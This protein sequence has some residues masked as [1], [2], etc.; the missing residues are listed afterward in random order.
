MAWLKLAN[1]LFEFVEHS[2]DTAAVA[3]RTPARYKGESEAVAMKVFVQERLASIVL[4]N[5]DCR[6]AS[7]DTSDRRRPAGLLTP[8]VLRSLQT[9]DLLKHEFRRTGDRTFLDAYRKVRAT[10]PMRRPAG[11]P[12]MQRAK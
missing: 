8:H 12:T 5:G 7:V 2:D 11:A 6:S 9:C 10:I 4:A 3:M 1:I